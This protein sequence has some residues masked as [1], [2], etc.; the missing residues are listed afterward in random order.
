MQEANALINE[1]DN[2]QELRTVIRGKDKELENIFNQILQDLEHSTILEM[3]P[4]ENLT[5]LKV[6]SDTEESANRILDVYLHGNINI[7]QITDKVYAMGK[8][9]AL[10]SGIVQKQANY[11][12]KIKPQIE[13]GDRKLKA[14][15]KRLRQ[16]IAV[17]S[18]EIY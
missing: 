16:Q 8:Q 13:T 5:K 7:P 1:N 17:T 9:I 4:R 18:N 14:K 6:T 12:R 3:Y 2:K 15:M 11:H 10:K